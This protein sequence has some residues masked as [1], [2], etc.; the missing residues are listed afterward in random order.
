LSARGGRKGKGEPLLGI[1]IL[2]DTLGIPNR[3][4]LTLVQILVQEDFILLSGR[5][6]MSTPRRSLEI[7]DLSE[8][9]HDHVSAK[10]SRYVNQERL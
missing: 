9:K 4:E 10:Y 7:V 2:S 5:L 1:V 8:S 3:Q 6:H